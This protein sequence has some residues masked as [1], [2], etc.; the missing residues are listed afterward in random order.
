MRG[1]VSLSLIVKWHRKCCAILY[2]ALGLFCCLQDLQGRPRGAQRPL[3]G[4]V[5]HYTDYG[6]NG[7]QVEFYYRATED[8]WRLIDGMLCIVGRTFYCLLDGP[9]DEL[10][11]FADIARTQNYV[12]SWGR[13]DMR[14]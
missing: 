6:A 2:R 4:R 3:K 11:Y 12:R 10:V 13:V 14:K 8:S 1:I 5:S 7:I 9:S